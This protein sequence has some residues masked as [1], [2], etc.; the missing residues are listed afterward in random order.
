MAL[1]M[2][3]VVGNGHDLSKVAWSFNATA[4]IN[5]RASLVGNV[6][7]F[8]DRNATIYA[9]DMPFA[10]LIERPVASKSQLYGNVAI[11]ADHR[12]PLSPL[13]VR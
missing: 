7:L 5:I 4:G 6:L 1:A 13:P 10:I 2:G 12:K 9:F 11:I 8:G 3:T